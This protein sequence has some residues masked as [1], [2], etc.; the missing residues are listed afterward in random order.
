MRRLVLHFD[1]NQTILMKDTAKGLPMEL[2][3]NKIL[4]SEAWGTTVEKEGGLVWRA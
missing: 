4:A 1:I 2:V 3:L